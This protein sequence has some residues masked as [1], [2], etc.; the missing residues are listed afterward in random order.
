[1]DSILEIVL[2]QAYASLLCFLFRSQSFKNVHFDGSYYS[3]IFCHRQSLSVKSFTKQNW[4]FVH[5]VMLLNKAAM[6]RKDEGRGTP[7]AI[8]LM[9]L[10]IKRL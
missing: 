3:Y 2:L 10:A 4:D 5:N 7:M 1:M 8:R 6:A 9:L